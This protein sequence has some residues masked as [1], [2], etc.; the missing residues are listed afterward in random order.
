MYVGPKHT[1]GFPPGGMFMFGCF[2]IVCLCMFLFSSPYFS[3]LLSFKV[4]N[5]I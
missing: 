4:C 2:Y 1:Y 3:F 5:Y